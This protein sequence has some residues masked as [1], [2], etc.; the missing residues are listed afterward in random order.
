[1]IYTLITLTAA[2]LLVAIDQ[3]IKAWAAS[4]LAPVGNMPLLP[5]VIELRFHLNTGAA[6]SMLEGK[7][8]FLIL[9]TGAALLAVAWY[10]LFRRPKKRVEYIGWLLVL[11][12]GLGNLID[13]VLHGQVVDYFNFLFMN[14]AVFNF[15]DV[16][17]TTGIGLLLL[18]LLLELLAERKNARAAADCAPEADD[19]AV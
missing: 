4:A 8:T 3:G 19:G 5:G 7:Q 1:M 2:A 15:A 16:L 13:R 9:F 17:I 10:L 6:F 11:A 12:G 14:F 18:S